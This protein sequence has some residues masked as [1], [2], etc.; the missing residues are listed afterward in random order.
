MVRTCHH[1]ESGITVDKEKGTVIMNEKNYEFSP[2]PF[3]ATTGFDA[4]VLI[5]SDSFY[6][7]EVQKA[8]LRVERAPDDQASEE[9]GREYDRE[10]EYKIA[11]VLHRKALADKDST[12]SID[13]LIGL[14]FLAENLENQ[15]LYEEAEELRGREVKTAEEHYGADTSTTLDSRRNL[16]TIVQKRKLD[17]Y[18]RR[19]KLE[20]LEAILEMDRPNSPEIDRNDME[21]SKSLERQAQD[22]EDQGT[23]SKA[24]GVLWALLNRRKETLGPYHSDT[25]TTMSNL[26]R[27]L[28][29]EKNLVAAEKLFWLALAMSEDR[30]GPEHVKTLSIMSNLAVCMGTSESKEIY[31]QQLERHLRS[32]D[33]DHPDM[34]TVKFNLFQ[35]RDENEEIQ[36]TRGKVLLRRRR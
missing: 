7:D 11:E 22:L 24:R 4:D 29:R 28:R 9:I 16:A 14:S 18:H 35:M 31:R 15:G 20:S 13:V 3:E 36:I 12:S 32:V 2:V 27:V 26:G 34:Y 21:V 25:L 30:W 17:T 19:W 1:E 33:F 10:G 23:L 6:E 5:K 8:L